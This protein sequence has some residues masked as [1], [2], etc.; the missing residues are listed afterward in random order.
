[1]RLVAFLAAVVAACAADFPT[2]QIIDDVKCIAEPSQSYALYL[3][4]K[5]SPDKPWSVVFAFDPGARGHLAVSRFQEAAEAY[6]YIVAGSN[7]SRNGSWDSSLAAVRAVPADLDGR[8]AIDKKRLYTAGFSG[9][10]RVAMQVALSSGKI[11][12]VVACSAG[13]P[14][15]KHKEVPFVIF[16]TAGTDDFNYQELLQLDRI[17]TTPHRVVIFEGGHDW[18]SSKLARE[19]LEWMELQAMKAGLR[20]RDDVFIERIFGARVAEAVATTNDLDAWRALRSIAADFE[21]LKDV[22]EFAGR[23]AGLQH[24]KTYKDAVRKER[25]GELREERMTEQVATLEN[26]LE[27]PAKREASLTELRDLLHDISRR[28]NAKDDSPE[29]RLHRRILYGTFVRSF[30]QVKDRQYQKLL[31][32][33]RK[34]GHR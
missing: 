14:V 23:A 1:M 4:S 5:Y 15:A 28:A 10:A 2:G 20:P 22:A 29:R 18:L 26:D 30:E 31:D 33:L 21:G 19:A 6:G 12:G 8:F 11:A 3:P 27:N 24:Q 25:D 7:N 34:S 9:G 13:F 17:V 32:D 16:G